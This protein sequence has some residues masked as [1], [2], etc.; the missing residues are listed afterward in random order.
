METEKKTTDPQQSEIDGNILGG[1]FE[2][3]VG[4]TKGRQ[5]TEDKPSASQ[6]GGV[7]EEKEK[8]HS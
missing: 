8:G 1:A 5:D 3:A 4:D 6:T 7:D 2:S